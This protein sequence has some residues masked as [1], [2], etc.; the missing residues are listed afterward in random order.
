MSLHCI[1]HIDS[2]SGTRATVRGT[3]PITSQFIVWHDYLK[4]GFLIHYPDDAVAVEGH[5]AFTTAVGLP[6][7]EPVEFDG[8]ESGSEGSCETVAADADYVD[9]DDSDNDIA[10]LTKDALASR[11]LPAGI[12]DTD[13]ERALRAK[14][15]SGA[16]VSDSDNEAFN[17]NP[18]E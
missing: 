15:V 6:G 2:S 18:S 3:A 12:A 1:K 9:D 5:E 13:A 11:P 14:L 7:T 16:E 17:C 4:D 8:D 10:K